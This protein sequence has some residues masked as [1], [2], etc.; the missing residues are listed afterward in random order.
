S[1]AEAFQTDYGTLEDELRDYIRKHTWPS[2]KAAARE[3]LQVDVRSLKTTVLSEAESEYYLGDLLLHIDRL[4]DAEIHLKNA[5]SKDAS[6]VPAQASF[7]ILR[8]RQ[9]DYDEAVTLLKTA[10][11]ND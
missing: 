11:E 2:L 9:R 7:G 3:T 8:V 5:L 4:A 1:F 6:L 10:V